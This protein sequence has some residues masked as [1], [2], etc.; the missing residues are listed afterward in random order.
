M[1]SLTLTSIKD[2]YKAPDGSD[3]TGKT[4]TALKTIAITGDTVKIEASK[5]TVVRGNQFSVTVTGRANE[6]YY[7]WVTGTASMTGGD[8]DQPPLMVP[9]QD[10]VSGP[11]MIRSSRTITP[12]GTTSTRVAAA[13]PSSRTCRLHRAMVS[14]TMQR[15][16]HQPAEPALLD[17]LTGANTDDKKYTIRV[18][19][20]FGGQYKSMRSM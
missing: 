16:R 10:N 14:T 2:N 7:V 18:E 15:S 19:N 12:L 5:D 6:F 3:Y 8:Q 13:R 17:S 1:P 9:N 20:N 11:P 4:V